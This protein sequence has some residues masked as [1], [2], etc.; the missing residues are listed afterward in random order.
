MKK[1]I[2]KSILVVLL[3]TLTAC[4]LS[5]TKL[6]IAVKAA[7]VECPIDAGNGAIVTEI[8]T[9]DNNVVYKTSVDE[10]ELVSVADFDNEIVISL[11]K[12][13]MIESIQNQN[14][15][16]EKE[17]IEL[18]KGANYNLVFRYIGNSSNYQVDIVISPDEI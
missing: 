18:I 12:A 9:E 13:A 17:F 15:K 6:Q 3:F 11:M 1:S 7:N 2:F 4:N 16:E 8:Y 14:S 10:N 5:T